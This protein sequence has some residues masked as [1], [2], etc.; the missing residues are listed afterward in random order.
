MIG[1]G[2]CTEDVFLLT[3]GMSYELAVIISLSKIA[4]MVNGPD[5]HD[6]DFSSFHD[7]DSSSLQTSDCRS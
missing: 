7:F 4:L 1:V 6:F 3:L 5:F 2:P